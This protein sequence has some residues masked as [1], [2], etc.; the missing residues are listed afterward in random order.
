[1][2]GYSTFMTDE[3]IDNE[4]LILDK[5]AKDSDRPELNLPD[6]ENYDSTEFS[7]YSKNTYCL[8]Q[9]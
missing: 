7:Y 6:I 4:K 5:S 2:N 1:M 8:L 3:F 9:T